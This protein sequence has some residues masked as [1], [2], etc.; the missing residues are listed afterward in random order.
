MERERMQDIA[1]D[2]FARLGY[3]ATSV[4]DIATAAG[5]SR[6]TFFRL[7][8]SKEAVVF[9]DHDALLARVE[10]RLANSGAE[11]TLATVT[12]AVKLVLMHFIAE[13]ERARARYGLT[14]T[15]AALKEREIV[16]GARYQSLFRR[17]LSAWGDGSPS[18][19]LRAELMAASVVAAHNHVL[20]RWLRG[21]TDDPHTEVEAAL[22]DVHRTH[23]ASQVDA[24]ALII[25]PSG[26][27]LKQVEA[28]V[29]RLVDPSHSA[30]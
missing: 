13:G 6:S 18:S 5:L 17:Y 22:A 28:A 20:R 3:E 14:S 30:P 21:E 25:V 16:S 1:L 7:F 29:R 9:F 24:P 4:D 12:D 2:L 27:S 10:E 26:T 8:G 23:G 15:V 19:E 11:G